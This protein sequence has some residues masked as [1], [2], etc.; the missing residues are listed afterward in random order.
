MGTS[1]AGVALSGPMMIELPAASILHHHDDDDDN[2]DDDDN[3]DGTALCWHA[4][5]FSWI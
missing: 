2:F 4:D 3:D 5:S 1:R